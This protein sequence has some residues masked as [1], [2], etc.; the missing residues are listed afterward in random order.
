[1]KLGI[2]GGLSPYSTIL[3]YKFIVEA[4]RERAGRDPELVIYSVPIQEFASRIRAGDLEGAGRLLQVAFE[5]LDRAGAGLFLIGANT[6]HAVIDRVP[7]IKPPGFIDIRDAVVPELV[8]RGYR[9]VGLLATKGTLRYRVYDEWLRRAGIEPVAPGPA[10]QNALMA[11]IEALA[12]GDI[13]AGVKAGVAQAVMDVASKGVD[14]IVYACTELS[15]IAD[16]LHV[17]L[18]VVDS[19]SLHALRAVDAMLGGGDE[20]AEARGA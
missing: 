11:A 14:A 15:L 18:P 12:R 4:Y 1:L 2:V 8:E 20:S 7:G 3:Y 9:R 17:R 5:A 19:L 6:P 16:R 10:A 13:G